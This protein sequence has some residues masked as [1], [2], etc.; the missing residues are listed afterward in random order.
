MEQNL[1]FFPI[2]LYLDPIGNNGNNADI[3]TVS[4]KIRQ[5]LNVLWQ[6]KFRSKVDKIENPFSKR[7]LPLRCCFKGKS[8]FITLIKSYLWFFFVNGKYSGLCHDFGFSHFDNQ[9]KGGYLI[10]IQ[11]QVYVWYF[12]LQNLPNL[13]KKYSLNQV[14]TT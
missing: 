12:M 8:I 4:V 6:N 14:S 11:M 9:F 10:T 1:L 13:P 3:I 7:S 2:K 5:L